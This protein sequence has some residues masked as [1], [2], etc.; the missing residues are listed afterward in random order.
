[1]GENGISDEPPGFAEAQDEW[2]PGYE[3]SLF[4]MARHLADAI[5]GTPLD[6]NAIRRAIVAYLGP[7]AD[8]LAWQLEDAV[9]ARWSRAYLPSTDELTQIFVHEDAFFEFV[10]SAW[11][12][13]DSSPEVGL[14]PPKMAPTPAFA[15]LDLPQWPTPQAMAEA[16]CLTSRE[17]IWLADVDGRAA[18]CRRQSARHYHITSIRKRNGGHRLIEA[19]KQR[20]RTIQREILTEILNQIEPN[21]AAAAYSKGRSVIDSAAKHAGERVVL[22]LD[23]RRFFQS[24]PARRVRVLFRC[25]GYP[26]PVARLLTGLTTTRTYVQVAT[27]E[28][29][30]RLRVPHLPQGAPTSPAL[31]NLCAGRLDRRL[32]GLARR[33]GAN[34]TRYADDLAFS[35]DG[36]LKK[37]W[38]RHLISNIAADEGFAIATEKSRL[39]DA[40]HRQTVTGIVVNRYVNLRRSEFDRLKAILTNCVRHGP[41]SQNH[42]GH[43]AFQQHLDGRVTWLERLNPQ[44]GAKLRALFNR[45]D[46]RDL[47]LSV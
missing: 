5:A 19:P 34:Y 20:L 4:P 9:A 24:I 18:R 39:M 46:W 8:H 1:M 6:T 42:A 16:L 40:S 15:T 31:A 29:R 7:G 2:S 26:L 13:G 44:R 30:M 41:A 12:R 14:R 22:T 23:L 27:S 35:G 43:P 33:L 38:L 10:M 37:P 3:P 45:I 28:D 11:G 36:I 47:D 21:P 32:N 17:L 25:L